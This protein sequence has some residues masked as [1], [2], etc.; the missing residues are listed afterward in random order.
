MMES[1]RK[2][3]RQ[4]LGEAFLKEGGKKKHYTLW[5]KIDI[6]EGA[7][8]IFQGTEE[9]IAPKVAALLN[10]DRIAPL[11]SGTQG[12]AYHI[13]NNR[14]MKL[15]K[16]QSEAYECKKIQG[17]SMKHLAN[18][19]NTYSLQGKHTGTYVI[20]SE[21]LQQD[22][23]VDT[24]MMWF[25]DWVEEVKPWRL[26]VK[27]NMHL[28][29]SNKKEF[30]KHFSEEIRTFYGNY[31]RKCNPA[32]WFLEQIFPL[33]EE[34]VDN[35]IQSRDVTLV[36]MGKKRNGNLGLF[37][38][39]YGDKN[40]KKNIK[41]IHVTE[42]DSN[43]KESKQTVY[44]LVGPPAIGKSTYI[45]AN[46]AF[47]DATIISRDDIVT[48]AAGKLNLTYDD[49]FKYPPQ[50]AI[51][52]EKVQG[53]E[54]FGPVVDNTHPKMKEAFPLA[55]ANTLKINA[56]VDGTVAERFSKALKSGQDIVVDMT[57][58]DKRARAMN[59]APLV[60]HDVKK[61]AVIFNF[62]DKDTLDIL[63]KLAYR[64]AQDLKKQGGSKT[65]TPDIIEKLLK[66]FERPTPDEGFDSIY[67]FD[68]LPTLRKSLEE[69]DVTPEDV[70]KKQ[71]PFQYSDMLDEF[72][73]SKSDV[74]EIAAM[75]GP[76]PTVESIQLK[77]PALFDEFAEYIYQATKTKSTIG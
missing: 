17:K 37:D 6:E 73:A 25:K 28:Y 23:S 27:D 13:P 15:T 19:Y 21:Y 41:A 1:L 54:K 44:V 24:A 18:I 52:G 5:T 36:N 14:V 8:E 39:G 16:D 11:A 34:L 61:V 65:I 9:E 67:D 33:Y 53:F 66:S 3:I 48:A 60:G 32:I 38:L 75:I 68:T 64:R 7:A 72:L 45:K 59:L 57:N 49:L 26:F 76:N 35:N 42:E 31:E 2:Y 43:N 50:D 56:L 51:K 47:K 30:I 58:M 55:Y 10:I 77:A 46:P 4:I 69:T 74:P 22:S 12:Y 40:D 29:K 70:N 63:S 71:L 62:Q 20:I